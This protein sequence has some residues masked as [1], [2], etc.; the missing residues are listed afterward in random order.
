M[1]LLNTWFLMAEAMETVSGGV[2]HSPGQTS[3]KPTCIICLGM[4]GS[5]KTT[6]VQVLGPVTK[7]YDPTAKRNS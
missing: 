3:N 7:I 1:D 6:F 4:A 2:S 5:G